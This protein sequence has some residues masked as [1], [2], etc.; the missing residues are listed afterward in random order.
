MRRWLGLQLLS[1]AVIRTQRKHMN[2]IL[3]LKPTLDRRIDMYGYTSVKS[4]QMHPLISKLICK[5]QMPPKILHIQKHLLLILLLW[6]L[7]AL[8][9]MP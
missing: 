1:D 5:F 4:N 8:H 9:P 6:N 7:S 2:V 3:S